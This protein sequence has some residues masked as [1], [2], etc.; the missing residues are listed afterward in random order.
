MKIS[1]LVSMVAG[2]E[3]Q[4]PNGDY[5]PV[6]VLDRRR[7]G[8]ASRT[9]QELEDLA[10]EMFND[11]SEI[12]ENSIVFTKA[13]WKAQF[14]DYA[15]YCN[16][17]VLGGGNPPTGE[18]ANDDLCNSLYKCYKCINVDYDH[19]GQYAAEV[20]EYT[21][22]YDAVD[23][24]I[25]CTNNQHNHNEECPHNICQCDRKFITGLL[26]NYK[27]CVTERNVSKCY[28]PALQHSNGFD[29][30]ECFGFQEQQMVVNDVCCGEYPWRRPFS[31][32]RH[33]CCADGRLRQHGTC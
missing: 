13:S 8:K 12:Q 3:M 4:T 1:Q 30:F 16:S 26:T 17:R 9:Y 10:V 14:M 18:D 19:T 32:S 7:G 2:L 22:H 27:D 31:E 11:D 33:E 6:Q 15:C 29:R 5:I 25:K 21:A 23:K 20:M 24:E 28:N